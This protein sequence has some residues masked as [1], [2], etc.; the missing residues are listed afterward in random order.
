MILLTG[1]EPAAFHFPAGPN[2]MRRK[3]QFLVLPLWEY[4][5]GKHQT[6]EIWFPPL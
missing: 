4:D 1:Y 2:T 3:E 5:L 6:A